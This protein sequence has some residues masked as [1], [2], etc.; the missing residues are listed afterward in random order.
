MFM[1][2]TALGKSGIV[3]ER[4]AA[5]LS[6]TGTPAHYVHGAEWTH[7][8]LGKPCFAVE[9]ICN[10]LDLVCFHWYQYNGK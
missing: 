7:G 6:S 1:Y 4:M 5:S 10:K 8:D 9:A 3:A 2:S